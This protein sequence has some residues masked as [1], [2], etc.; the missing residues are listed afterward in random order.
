MPKVAAVQLNS[1]VRVEDNLAKVKHYATQAAN[2]GAKLILLPEMFCQMG[3]GKQQL[4]AIAE[5]QGSGPV[6]TF[7]ADLSK[8]LGVWIIAGTMPIKTNEDRVFAACLVFNTQGEQVARYDKIHLFNAKLNK[9]SETYNESD[10]TKPGHN[11]VMVET[12]IGKIGLTVCYDVRFPELYRTLVNL[13]SEIIVVPS[14]FVH[15]TGL[16]HWHTLLKARAIEN[17]CFII[18]SNQ[19]GMHENNRRT[20]GHSLIVSPWG[21]VMA[22]LEESPGYIIADIKLDELHAIRKDL[23]SIDHQRLIAED[24]SA[25][26]KT[27]VVKTQ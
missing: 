4:L 19:T 1:K 25:A 15:T 18:A 16:A 26:L 23:P 27:V 7:L 2:D 11:I 12:P 17:F 14:A 10:Y 22:E 24:G 13:G 5:E 9:S 21:E 3:A 6:Q 20:Y 8:E